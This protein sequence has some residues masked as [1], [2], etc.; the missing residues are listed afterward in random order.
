MRVP[1]DAHGD[2]GAEVEHAAAVG[3]EELAP[4][5]AHEDEGRRSVVRVEALPRQGQEFRVRRHFAE[6]V[7]TQRRAG[8]ATAEGS[9]AATVERET[10]S[11]GPSAV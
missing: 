9:R 1:E 10:E 5:P 7:S 6:R 2:A 8:R 4:A 3:V 11:R